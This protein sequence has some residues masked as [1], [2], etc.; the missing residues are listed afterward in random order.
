[1][2]SDR[3]AQ[4]SPRLVESR[5]AEEVI[6]EAAQKSGYFIEHIEAD[7][8][9]IRGLYGI[10]RSLP[11]DGWLRRGPTP[12]E[13]RQGLSAAKIG[14][15]L[16]A[17]GT[18]LSA[19][20]RVTERF[21]SDVDYCVFVG[22]AM[23]S[24]KAGM[25][26]RQRIAG[27]A[28]TEVNG[29]RT[30]AG[31]R[32][33][34]L[35]RITP[36]GGVGFKLDGVIEPT[37]VPSQTLLTVKSMIARYLPEVVDSYPELGGF[38]VPVLPVSITAINKLDALHR[39]AELGGLA[40]RVRDVYDLAAIAQSEHADEVRTIVDE[41]AERESA[42]Q[43]RPVLRPRDGYGSAR[44]YDPTSAEYRVLSTAYKSSIPDLLPHDTPIPDFGASMRAIRELDCA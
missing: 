37:M 29:T 38:K 44:L 8:W 40:D 25:K 27:W 42:F 39:R 14:Q 17:G 41:W 3:D 22:N 19:A 15:W 26:I 33:V 23:L 31:K 2:A 36:R 43:R 9:L 18:S 20:W 30:S 4:S 32:A 11:R 1:M 16:F 21:S 35:S 34:R 13:R 7:Y 24:K 12:R 5:H 6:N 28:T 10:A